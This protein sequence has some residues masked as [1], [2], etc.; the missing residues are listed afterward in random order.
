MRS[1][2]AW[3]L[4]QM[5]A[6]DT[7]IEYDRPISISLLGAQ[8]ALDHDPYTTDSYSLSMDFRPFLAIPPLNGC[9]Y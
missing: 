8:I 2:T 3:F 1:N 9:V 4:W 5:L 6:L 7:S